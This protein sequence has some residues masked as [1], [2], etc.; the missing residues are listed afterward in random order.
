TSAQL[1]ARSLSLLVAQY[2]GESW[3]QMNFGSTVSA[4]TTTYIKIDEP[5]PTNG[6]NIDLLQTVGGLLGLLENNILLTEVYDKNGNKINSSD[7]LTN[8]VTD[9]DGDSY[10]A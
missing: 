5:E 1:E 6:L 7:V 3:L 4:N 2:T 9:A 10:L 8:I